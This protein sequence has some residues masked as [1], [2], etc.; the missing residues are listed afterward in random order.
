MV[1]YSE[2]VFITVELRTKD[3]LLRPL[4]ATDVKLDYAAV[5]E[6]K[7]LLRLWSQSGWPTDDFT[8]ADNLKDLQ[9]HEKE[10]LD[11]EAFTFTVMS[12]TETECLGAI[13]IIPFL[14][15]MEIEFSAAN[16]NDLPRV[17]ELK[18]AM[19]DDSGHGDLLAADAKSII[20]N[21][22]RCLYQE[23]KAIHYV[24]RSNGI[25]VATAGGFIKSDLPF[26]YFVNSWYGFIG[27]VYT[28]PEFRGKGIATKLSKSV[29][30]W[31]KKQGISMVRLLA[32]DEG[33]PI[34]EKMG[35]RQSD[36]MEIEI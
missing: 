22:Y 26:R 19:F 4:R 31:L 20:A 23:N 24:A 3:F 14:C 10:H 28:T 9:R 34:Y 36:E 30:D 5:I 16:I 29:M 8:L 7:D 33:R 35:F 18:L 17:I 6:S 13:Y 2:D 27:D 12:L 32:S 11:R 15:L 1:F 21:D 25:I